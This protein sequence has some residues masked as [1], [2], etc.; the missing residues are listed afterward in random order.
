MKSWM[1]ERDLLIAQTMV[2]V[3]EVAASRPS[4]VE[5][6]IIAAP[7]DQVQK[8]EQPIPVEPERVEVPAEP[9]ATLRPR[10]DE[11]AEI[12]KRVASFKAHQARLSQDREQFFHSVMAKIDDTLARQRVRAQIVISGIGLTSE[13][14]PQLLGGQRCAILPLL[15]VS[16]CLTR[17]LIF[18]GANAVILD[19]L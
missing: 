15:S 2:F 16:D 17:P 8:E 12:L 13:Q 18:D 11:R 3:E 14:R 6:Q 4:R 9:I 10:I 19:T 5:P 1:E 7:P